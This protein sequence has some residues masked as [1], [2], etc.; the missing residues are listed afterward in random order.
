MSSHARMGP[1]GTLLCPIGTQALRLEARPRP[2]QLRCA[3]PAG[4]RRLAARPVGSCARRIPGHGLGL[5]QR[6]QPSPAS[7][8]PGEQAAGM[9][10]ETQSQGFTR[11]L[12]GCSEA[13]QRTSGA[14][15]RR[16]EAT[17][18]ECA[19]LL[20]SWSRSGI[21]PHC[22]TTQLAAHRE[23]RQTARPGAKLSARSQRWPMLV[24]WVWVHAAHGA[25]ARGRP[26]E[27]GGARA[28]E[29]GREGAGWGL[30]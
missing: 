22:P 24:R 29:R 13:G 15:S 14:T 9:R 7:S 19:N 26:A 3:Q 28:R 27:G 11:D 23:G 10:W 17:R 5:A 8:D 16:P 6:A 25:T 12:P 2:G 1:G 21:R 30:G 4:H 20:Q 18:G